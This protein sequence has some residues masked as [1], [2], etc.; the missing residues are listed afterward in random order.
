LLNFTD[1]YRHGKYIGLIRS[2]SLCA[3]LVVVLL[4]LL[5]LLILLLLLLLAS[6]NEDISYTI[7]ST[8][9]YCFS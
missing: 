6:I 9:N 1:L 4:F 8:I 2:V 3:L 5:F 7:T